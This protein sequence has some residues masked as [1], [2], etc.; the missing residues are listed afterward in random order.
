[1]GNAFPDEFEKFEQL[2]N[3]HQYL[4]KVV[5][6]DASKNSDHYPFYEKGARAFFIYGMGKSGRYHHHSDTLDNMSLGGYT[7]LFKLITE[8]INL[9]NRK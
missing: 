3:R 6:R 1:C 7:G 5:S 9:Y 4:K 2:N 8:Y